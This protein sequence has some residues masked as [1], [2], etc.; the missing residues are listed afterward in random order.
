[1]SETPPADGRATGWWTIAGLVAGWLGVAIGLLGVLLP[2]VSLTWQPL[3]VLAAFAG[4]L[5][6]AG[7]I[8]GAL[9]ALQRNW[10]GVGVAGLVVLASIGWQL[11][12][13]VG[14]SVA[15]KPKAPK[16]VVLQ[17]NLKIGAAD[18][19]AITA[20]VRSNGVDVLTVE[21]LTP[22]AL[23]ALT[24]AGLEALLPY[25]L[26]V[27]FPGGGGTGIWSRYP[28]TEQTR[29][30]DFSFELLSA[31]I[32]PPGADD[33]MIWAVHLLPPWPYDAKVWAAET[34]RLHGLIAEQARSHRT[35]IV[36][37]DFNATWTNRQFRQLMEPS[38]SDAAERTGDGWR[39]TYPTDRFF[40]PLLTLDHVLL[41]GADPTS[42]RTVDLPGSDHR[43]LLVNLRLD[44]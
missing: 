24:A 16:L 26:A 41:H 13:L 14:S 12:L 42:V 30:D 6:L 3:I 29:H 11:P 10:I 4:Y 33:V 28:L 43:G 7:V 44:G 9:L 39:T 2:A 27:P 17:A 37:G 1:M 5:G 15:T 31:R 35:V 25:R 38:Y 32:T 21:E 20:L 40:P 22:A 19:A 34:R 8:G 36:A 23:S 18:P